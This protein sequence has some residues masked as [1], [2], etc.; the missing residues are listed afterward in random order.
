M[1]FLMVHF[2]DLKIKHIIRV[3]TKSGKSKIG[4][5]QKKVRK[6]QGIGYKHALDKKVYHH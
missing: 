2:L 6:S 1:Y 3:S 4:G 5:F